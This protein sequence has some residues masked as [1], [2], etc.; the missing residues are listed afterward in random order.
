MQNEI[1]QY[2]GNTIRYIQSW[3]T[4]LVIHF[5]WREVDGRVYANN[6]QYFEDI[7]SEAC[8]FYIDNYQLAQ[9]CLRD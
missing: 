1:I 2:I 7:P 3:R 6:T 9:K 4:V 5:L 8:N